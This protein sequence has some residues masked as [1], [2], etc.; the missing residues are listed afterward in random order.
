MIAHDVLDLVADNLTIEIEKT[1]EYG[2]GGESDQYITVK[3]VIAGRVISS[4]YVR[5]D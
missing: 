5:I 2:S 4:D 1:S 3:L